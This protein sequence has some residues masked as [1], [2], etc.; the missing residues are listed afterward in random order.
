MLRAK[1]LI[2]SM[3]PPKVGDQTGLPS[4]NRV[5]PMIPGTHHP[6][7]MP[8]R[9]SLLTARYRNTSRRDRLRALSVSA[10]WRCVPLFG[11]ERRR[12]QP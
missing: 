1:F 6:R 4:W 2:S 5:L 8:L 12:L 3:S 9:R 11:C 10:L 7:V